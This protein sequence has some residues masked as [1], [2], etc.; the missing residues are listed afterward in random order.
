VSEQTA[1]RF[2]PNQDVLGKRIRSARANSPWLTV[3]GVVGNVRDAADPGDPAGTWFL[4]YAQQ[5]A[6][7]AA[8]DIFLM[9]RVQSDPANAVGGLKRA[10]GRVDGTLAAYRVAEM[11]HFY[12]ETL[13]RERLGARIVAILRVFGLLLAVLGIYG[14]MSF[15]VAQRAREIGMR[16]ALGARR[17]EILSLVL[18]RAL[19][20]ALL[21]LAIGTILAAGLNRVLVSVLAE[22]R[23]LELAVIVSASIT[24]LVIALLASYIP[25][26]RA[27]RV[28]PLNALRSD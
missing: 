23:S 19:R 7:S 24:L 25:A 12:S 22:V 3:V 20:L 9:V 6:T 16:L 17:R 26:T 1:R 21:G 5:A 4:P 15:A 14:V 27:A 10:I 13:E 2:W 8:N 18:F 28:D 11:D